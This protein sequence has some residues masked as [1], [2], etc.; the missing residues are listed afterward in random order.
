MIH[1]IND[2]LGELL[3]NHPFLFFLLFAGVALILIASFLLAV[4]IINPV[5]SCEITENGIHYEF[6]EDKRFY[7]WE[8][9]RHAK[10]L[11]HR[12]LGRDFEKIFALKYSFDLSGPVCNL[13]YDGRSDLE[14]IKRVERLIEENGINLEVV[15]LTEADLKN[16]RYY[17]SF[18]DKHEEMEYVIRLFSR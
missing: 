7:P 8:E 11:P 10:L 12:L 4:E 17:Y 1:R 5:P 9:I 15:P 2:W 13:E 14:E 3:Y 6:K 16:M 18:D